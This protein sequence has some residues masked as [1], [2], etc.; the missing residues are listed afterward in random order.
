MFETD[1]RSS[2]N[3]C[4]SVIDEQEDLSNF[5]LGTDKD[6]AN[7]STQVEPETLKEYLQTE[8][9]KENNAYFYKHKEGRSRHPSKINSPYERGLS[10][11][12]MVDKLLHS[13]QNILSRVSS[14]IPLLRTFSRVSSDSGYQSTPP[15]RSISRKQSLISIGSLLH[16]ETEDVEE[17][18]FS[19]VKVVPGGNITDDY[20]LLELLGEGAFSKVYLAESK[21]DKGGLAAVKVINKDELCKDEDK[22]FLVDKEIEIMAQLD[23]P[24][25]VKLYEVY[26]NSEQVCLVMELAKGGEVFDKLLEYG[27]LTEPE[28]AKLL[29]QILEAISYLHN[30]GIVHRDLKPENLLFYDNKLRSKVMVTDFGLSDYEEDLSAESPVCGTA[31]YLAPEVIKRSCSSRAQDMWS[32]GVI[33]YIILCGYPP[34]FKDNKADEDDSELLKQI[35]RGKYKFHSNFWDEI[36]DDA[37]DFVCGLMNVDPMKRMSVQEALHHPWIIRYTKGYFD[38]NCV[39]NLLQALAVLLLTISFFYLYFFSLS[40]YFNIEY[41]FVNWLYHSFEDLIDRG[42]EV[43][44]N[45]Y[46]YLQNFGDSIQSPLKCF[47]QGAFDTS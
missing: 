11:N 22:M 47:L 10:G 25:I 37:K 38:E 27:S 31:T 6:F 40:K 44:S 7:K 46:R 35:A 16:S 39:T 23:H 45:S 32:L 28:A 5:H 12:S 1:Y 17:E 18:F 9:D 41:F 43:M 30:L 36:S 8:H 20:I 15:S 21:Q 24:N 3:E 29:Q 34:F 26:V 19:H 33:S 14:I 42:A 13:T 2:D 4:D